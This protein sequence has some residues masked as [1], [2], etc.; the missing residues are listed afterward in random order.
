VGKHVAP[1]GTLPHPLV[2]AALSRRAADGPPAHASG[3]AGD[4]QGSGTG[5]LGW[6]EP[7]APDGG[8]VGWPGTGPATDAV[9][10]SADREDT[11]RRRGW[12]R[13]FRPSSA[14]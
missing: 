3:A 1:D 5:G 6:P 7:P 11:G 13:F 2:A 8:R 12:R 4:E 10:V 9:D 14:A